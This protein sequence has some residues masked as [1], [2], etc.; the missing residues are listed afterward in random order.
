MTIPRDQPEYLL[1]AWVENNGVGGHVE[2]KPTSD[3][4]ASDTDFTNPAYDLVDSS[5]QFHALYDIS[6]SEA[7]DDDLDGE[8]DDDELGEF[9]AW[10]PEWFDEDD[11][12]GDLELDWD[13]DDDLEMSNSESRAN[14]GDYAKDD[15]GSKEDYLLTHPYFCVVPNSFIS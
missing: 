14:S 4:S 9:T 8:I 10:E 12:E 11:P 15:D 3:F 1:Q 7:I 5:I 2:R 13:P 6:D